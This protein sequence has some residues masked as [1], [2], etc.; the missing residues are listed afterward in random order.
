M[1]T[2]KP[3]KFLLFASLYYLNFYNILRKLQNKHVN[4]LMYHRFS[5]NFEPFKIHRYIFENQIK[6]LINKYNFISLTHYSDYLNGHH[7]HLPNNPMIITI[8][9]GYEDNFHY[10]FPVLKKYSIPAT[11]FITTDFINK[12][13]WLWFN[14][15]KYILKN[16]NCH[17]FK[18]QLGSN[19]K[20]FYLDSLDNKRHA[21]LSIFNYC[22]TISAIQIDDLLNQL[23]EILNVRTPKKTTIDF[24]PLTWNQIKE[25]K[26][27]NIEIGSHTCTHPILSRLNPDELTNE[28][29]NSKRE[30]ELKLGTEINSLCYPVGT[31]EDISEF[32]VNATMD[33][34]YSCAVTTIPGRNIGKNANKFLLK[35]VTINNDNKI[36]L[37]KILT[38]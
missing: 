3:I 2:L 36:K 24:Q 33:A 12:K 35:R 18:F 23:S 38:L 22:K 1:T 6:Y 25:M 37:D 8:D 30:I 17:E 13:S 10:A 4:I 19:L 20:K 28:L 5:A 14:K 9:D 15:I 16:T 27:Y 11:I 34:G 21:K 26:Q 31:Q 29:V 7:P 32:V